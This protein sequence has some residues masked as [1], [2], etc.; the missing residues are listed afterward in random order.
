MLKKQMN[1][2]IIEPP[3]EKTNNVVLNRSDINQAVQAQNISETSR[4]ITKH[5]LSEV[6][7]C[8]GIVCIGFNA[9]RIKTLVSM[10][11]YIFSP[12]VWWHI[13]IL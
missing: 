1:R 6:L 7:L 10:A 2:C 8:E 3:H 9:G 13:I 5:T 11:T 12:T 4:P